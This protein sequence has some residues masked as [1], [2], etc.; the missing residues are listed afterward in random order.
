LRQFRD[1]VTGQAI[2]VGVLGRIPF[3]IAPYSSHAP[4]SVLLS[5]KPGKSG[6][7]VGGGLDGAPLAIDSKGVTIADW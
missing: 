1:N 2:G 3:H 6:R 7:F 4:A 5:G